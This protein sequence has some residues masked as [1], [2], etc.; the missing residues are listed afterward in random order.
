MSLFFWSFVA[1]YGLFVYYLAVMNLVRAREMGFI[2]PGTRQSLFLALI[3]LPGV[4]LD[5][6]VNMTIC[7]LLF[8]ELPKSWKELVTGR[9]KRHCGKQTWRGKVATWICH[10]LLDNFDPSGRHC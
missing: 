1:V 7:N 10:N 9:L 4:F 3:V 8:L 6:A 5:W 2:K